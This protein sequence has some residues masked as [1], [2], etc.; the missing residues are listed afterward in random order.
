MLKG[1][2]ETSKRAN[3]LM[4]YKNMH[5]KSGITLIMMHVNIVAEHMAISSAKSVSLT[6]FRSKANVR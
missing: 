5:T 1:I 2:G 4:K 3:V 6:G